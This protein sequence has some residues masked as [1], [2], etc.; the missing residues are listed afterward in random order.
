MNDKPRALRQPEERVG[1]CSN[2]ALPPPSFE[3]HPDATLVLRLRAR[4]ES[5]FHLLYH[6][7]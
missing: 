6:R 1:Q 5:A 7:Y 3:Q 4:D 2:V